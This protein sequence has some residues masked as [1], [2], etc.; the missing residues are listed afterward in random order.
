MKKGSTGDQLNVSGNFNVIDRQII[1]AELPELE[2][3]L[4]SKPENFTGK[5]TLQRHLKNLNT[6]LNSRDPKSDLEL[7]MKLINISGDFKILKK[8]IENGL[9]YIDAMALA[10]ESNQIELFLD[11]SSSFSDKEYWENLGDAYVLQDSKHI[12]HALFYNLFSSKRLHKSY[13]MTKEET[14]YFSNLE[15][16]FKIYR[17]CTIAESNSKRFGIS[18][19]LNI[20]IAQKFANNKSLKD[21]LKTTVIEK[22]IKKDQAL[23]YFNRREE[24]EIIYIHS[25]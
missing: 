4:E 20:D 16:E 7:A 6:K 14:E 2:K 23:A 12:N 25:S 9:T 24:H 11:F 18:W 13:L 19:S 3:I 15:S 21:K 8:S 10:P 1:K 17:G 5:T 22:T